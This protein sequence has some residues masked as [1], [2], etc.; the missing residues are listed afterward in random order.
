MK[1]QKEYFQQAKT[2]GKSFIARSA[3]GAMFASFGGYLPELIAHVSIFG[4][5]AVVAILD[6]IPTLL[7][8]LDE[9]EKGKLI[10]A[11]H[12]FKKVLAVA[13]GMAIGGV[14]LEQFFEIKQEDE[15]VEKSITIILP[16]FA[17]LLATKSTLDLINRIEKIL[18]TNLDAEQAINLTLGSGG[19]LAQAGM[20]VGALTG[21]VN[22]GLANGINAAIS[23][24]QAIVSGVYGFWNLRK[25]KQQDTEL[26]EGLLLNP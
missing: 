8:K 26:S 23:G 15:L 21:T 4:G 20:I 12:Y 3:L 1:D 10:Q 7:E 22:L 16:S 9:K 5:G 24:G 6:I 17:V 18:K 11:L 14:Y 19:T 25:A 13:E 2:Y